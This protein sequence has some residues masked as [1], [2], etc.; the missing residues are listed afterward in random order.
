MGE[1]RTV[2]KGKHGGKRPLRK[3]RHRWEK[4]IR[5]DLRDIGWCGYSVNSFGLE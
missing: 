2:Y 4:G 5:I 1:E 3:L